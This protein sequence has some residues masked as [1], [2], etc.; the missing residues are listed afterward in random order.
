MKVT[1]HIFNATIE[2]SDKFEAAVIADIL[3]DAGYDVDET[4]E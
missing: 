1:L 4:I 3:E 2:C